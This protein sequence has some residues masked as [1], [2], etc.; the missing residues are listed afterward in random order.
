MLDKIKKESAAE[1]LQE[2]IEN[3]TKEMQEAATNLE[4]ERAAALRD[5]IMELQ[6]E[7]G[8]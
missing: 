1:N 4:F 3:M 5:Q 7:L 6:Q 8:Q 2:I